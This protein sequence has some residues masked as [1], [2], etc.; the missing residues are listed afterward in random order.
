[1]SPDEISVTVSVTFEDLRYFGASIRHME[2]GVEYYS[3]REVAHFLGYS[4]WTAFLT[5]LNRAKKA[6]HPYSETSHHFR[7]VEKFIPTIGKR[8]VRVI[9]DY[10]LSRHAFLLII[11]NADGYLPVVAY[12]KNY[13]AQAALALGETAA[14]ED[15]LQADHDPFLPEDDGE[16]A[17]ETVSIFEAL[18]IDQKRFEA[19]HQKRSEQ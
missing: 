4:K 2:D 19:R 9:D 16:A 10:H 8:L 12:G 3:A 1:M 11:M 17:T 15:E 14:Q 6:C 13:I 18:E 5:V 7:P